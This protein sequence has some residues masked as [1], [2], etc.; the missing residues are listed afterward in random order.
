MVLDAAKVKFS[1]QYTKILSFQ[2]S[3][4]KLLMIVRS[5]L[6]QDLNDLLRIYFEEVVWRLTILN[7]FWI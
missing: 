2:V 1:S 3:D 7:V 4:R 6:C 5:I